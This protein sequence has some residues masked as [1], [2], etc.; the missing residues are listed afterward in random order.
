[1]LTCKLCLLVVCA[2]PFTVRLASFGIFARR[3]SATLWLKPEPVGD[4][5]QLVALQAALQQAVPHCHEQGSK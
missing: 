1:M 2:Q 3:H 5:D 4:A